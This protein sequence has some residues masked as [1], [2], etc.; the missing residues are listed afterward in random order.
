MAGL[1]TESNVSYLT[2]LGFTLSGYSRNSSNTSGNIWKPSD[3]IL[4]T[5]SPNNYSN[6]EF[7]NAYTNIANGYAVS[8]NASSNTISVV[9]SG[10]TNFISAGY[11]VNNVI[12]LSGFI[13]SENNNSF[14]ISGVTSNTITV[15]PTYT[16][17]SETGVDCSIT[18]VPV[19]LVSS[20]DNDIVYSNISPLPQYAF[21]SYQ[22]NLLHSCSL[23]Y[24]INEVASQNSIEN[25]TGL[26]ITVAGNGFYS[27][28][29]TINSSNSN[30]TLDS[31]NNSP[32]S[33]VGYLPVYSKV[34]TVGS[35]ANNASLYSGNKSADLLSW[36]NALLTSD[37][38]VFVEYNNQFYRLF[39]KIHYTYDT[40]NNKFIINQYSIS[41]LVN[42]SNSQNLISG[43]TFYIIYPK[44]ES[45]PVI[46]NNDSITRDTNISIRKENKK[47]NRITFLDNS[48]NETYIETTK[49]TPLLY[50]DASSGTLLEDLQNTRNYK[51][52]LST[53][54]TK[55]YLLFNDST[56]TSNS[57]VVVNPASPA[58]TGLWN[59]FITPTENYVGP[60][61]FSFGLWSNFYNTAVQETSYF[62]PY[63]SIDTSENAQIANRSSSRWQSV[64]SAISTTYPTYFFSSRDETTART[65][66]WNRGSASTIPIPY[67][68]NN[69]NSVQGYRGDTS[70]FTRTDFMSDYS[71]AFS[72]D[73]QVD[74]YKYIDENN[75]DQTSIYKNGSSSD[76][77]EVIPQTEL[78]EELFVSSNIL[79][80]QVNPQSWNS[81]T[82]YDSGQCVSYLNTTWQAILP[83]IGIVPSIPDWT[84][85]GNSKLIYPNRKVTST[86]LVLYTSQY[87]DPFDFSH[88][89]SYYVASS[90]NCKPSF[91]ANNIRMDSNPYTGN[92]ISESFDT[93]DIN[94]SG[95]I[96]NQDVYTITSQNITNTAF[97]LEK[98]N[99]FVTWKQINSGAT[100]SV[101]SSAPLTFPSIQVMRNGVELVY[102]DYWGFSTNPNSVYLTPAC[103]LA[104]NDTIE[105]IYDSLDTTELLTY[106]AYTDLT[107]NLVV[108]ST[109]NTQHSNDSNIISVSFGVSNKIFPLQYVFNHNPI[110]SWY[111]NDTNDYISSSV[112]LTKIISGTSKTALT[113]VAFMYRD[114]AVPDVIVAKNGIQLTYGQDWK[115]TS[116]PSTI[117]WSYRVVLN[118]LITQSLQPYD[119]ISIEYTS[120][121]GT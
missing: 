84:I 97:I 68:G 37:L 51:S 16:L 39:K 62:V 102:G 58:D 89:T 112:D 60:E 36:T 19:W 49:Y 65:S 87:E 77:L 53:L 118:Q 46:Y 72:S 56:G 29:L 67:K 23:G 86:S 81:T 113:P 91:Y 24:L 41:L 78:L 117:N 75:I 54:F 76:T 79:K 6:T 107:G 71:I 9:F 92:L 80:T 98:Q 42:D 101:G 27:D 38:L 52:D 120:I 99:V 93:L 21:Y 32:V 90:T 18:S 22:T 74:N 15:L 69:R 45:N 57:P 106:P 59:V 73:Y 70:L 115:F 100:V 82:L 105:I 33:F 20:S 2:S 30:I 43:L 83:T 31:S 3:F 61:Q 103:L 14:I 4:S 28:S 40:I 26:S 5:K 50:F 114:L 116:V 12:I 88:R 47:F 13:N 10:S 111:R 55:G 34:K 8:I 96:T 94:I 104:I 48:S 110:I 25:M 17:I 121:L 35:I 1:N 119:V 63:N 109:N 7:T 11:S 44:L 64:V 108:C 85:I 95:L 66:I